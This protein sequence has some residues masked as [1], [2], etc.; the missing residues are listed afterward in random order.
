MK[1]HGCFDLSKSTSHQEKSDRLLYPDVIRAAATVG[2]VILH[3]CG[4]MMW[5]LTPDMWQFNWLVSA[6]T[7]V[8]CVVPLFLM[9]SG[10][11]LLSPE[12]TVTLSDLFKKYI[13]RLV[14]AYIGWS[15]LY[16]VFMTIYN[17]TFSSEGLY[18]LWKLF[19]V[20]H[21]H[22]WFLPMMI[23]VYLTIPFF[24]GITEKRD[25]RLLHYT[26]VV[27]LLFNVLYPNFY[28]TFPALSN[29]LERIDPSWFGIYATYFF[30]GYYFSRIKVPRSGKYIWLGIIA[31]SAA[32]FVFSVCSGSAAQGTLDESKWSPNKTPMVIY[33]ISVFM[34]FRNY[35]DLVAHLP[36]LC[37]FVRKLSE[38]SFTVYLCHDL[39]IKI[40]AKHGFDSLTWHPVISVPV[41]TVVVLIASMILSEFLLI[42][43]EN[44][45]KVWNKYRTKGDTVPK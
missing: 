15:F 22:L 12:K 34:V 3:V 4:G 8:H 24:R 40:L 2:V 16:A 9:L 31:V 32:W 23:G 35:G 1:K 19:F 33:T 27:L 44:I 25:S 14:I 20:G 38:L 36:R 10:M 6:D 17:G 28:T 21:Y 29:I 41:L 39:F 5:A 7:I 26:L 30:A 45:K 11:L 43:K 37:S 42:C 13:V 18:G